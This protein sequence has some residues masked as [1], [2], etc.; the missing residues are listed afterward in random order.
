VKLLVTVPWGAKL[1][2]AEMMLWTFLSNHDRRRL[3]ATVVFFESGPFEREVAGLG[4]DTVVL[5]T[6]RL[7]EA[8]H[9]ASAVATLARLLDESSP[10][11]VLN[12]VA[13]AQI[14]GGAAA[15]RAGMSRRVV[16]WQHG[17]SN[18][19]WMDRV[20]TLIPARAVGCSSS[21]VATAQRRLWPHRRTFTVHPGVEMPVQASP[22]GSPP[23]DIPKHRTV[24]GII[25]RL[26]EWKG[27][28]RFLHA[29]AQ[30]VDRGLD[31]HGLIVGG[32]AHGFSAGYGKHLE[33]VARD[34]GLGERVTM[35]GQI[36]DP[37]KYL[38]S[39]DLLV[40]AS[41]AEPFGIVLVEAMAHGVPVI[42]VAD[43]GPLD[44][45]VPGVSGL[46]VDT[47][48][49]ESLAQA[50]A[51]L[52]AD[53]DRRRRLGEAGR[54][55]AMERFTATHMTARLERHLED[56]AAEASRSIP[57]QPMPGDRQVAQPGR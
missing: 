5:P 50:M 16:W 20:A 32:E 2:G 54:K 38:G 43:A 47:P 41:R 8:R 53:P 40:S 15:M 10:D 9:F 55:R 56:L 45:V 18:G 25:G 48:E 46:L 27:Q 49:P 1:G 51:E 36:P 35:T 3:Q 39:M 26:Q 11:L 52:V 6:G 30:L 22:N 34:L 23:L 19:H 42:A 31:V 4:V 14:Y 29:L 13:K 7:R 17:V 44:I 12:W 57:A 21:A 28:H 24:I 33:G 37:E